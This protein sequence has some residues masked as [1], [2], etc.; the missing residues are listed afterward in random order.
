MSLD[1][2]EA[3]I[4]LS[5]LHQKQREFIAEA[6]EFGWDRKE[7][8]G[9]FETT[10]KKVSADWDAALASSIKKKRKVFLWKP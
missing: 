6:E 3:D 2:Y 8:R 5:F 4:L 10:V 7:A 1:F 9:I